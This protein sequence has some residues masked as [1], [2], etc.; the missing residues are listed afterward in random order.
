MDL[1]GF[2]KQNGHLEEYVRSRRKGM[3]KLE[4]GIYLTCQGDGE[5]INIA[6]EGEPCW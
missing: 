1:F 3:N 6:P 4:L 2:V 5:E